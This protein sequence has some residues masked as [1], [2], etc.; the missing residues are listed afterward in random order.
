MT[1]EGGTIAETTKVVLQ[2]QSDRNEDRTL[3]EKG[4]YMKEV[5]T[6]IK[7]TLEKAI[8]DRR[9][10]VDYL[11]STALTLLRGNDKL[12]ECS[13]RSI[14]AA[15]IQAVQLDLR[16][17][18]TLGE[19]YLVP[20]HDKRSGKREAQFMIGYRGFLKLAS[21]SRALITARTVY[22]W[23]TFDYEF[24]SNAFIKHRPRP[25][26][27]MTPVDYPSGPQYAYA[28]ADLDGRRLFDV[29][30]K[31]E[32]EKIRARSRSYAA[33]P[34][35]S[36]W[37][38]DPDEMWR[39]TAVRRLAKYLPLSVEFQKAADLDELAAAEIS[40]ELDVEEETGEVKHVDVAEAYQEPERTEEEKKKIEATRKKRMAEENLGELLN[41]NA[42][43]MARMIS[44]TNTKQGFELLK[45][46]IVAWTTA[47]NLAE[48]DA[49][50]L[51][52]I[53]EE[54]IEKSKR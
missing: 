20:F 8:P 1:T 11:I 22:A 24:G 18:K 29:M 45:T 53:L 32:V 10:S 6:K 36:I 14:A 38:T 34:E 16:L 33:D 3:E 37:T 25:R 50:N 49:T 30:E 46:T 9:I 15:V 51:T 35:T 48:K 28:Y 40:Q 12:L 2:G 52:R 23:D 21:R 42:G 27:K 43:E 19:A 17:D 31:D 13:P 47:G 5:F 39:K 4:R 41:K 54:K 44:E 7:G 26:P